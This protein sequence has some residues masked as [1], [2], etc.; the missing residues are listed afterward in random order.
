MPAVTLTPPTAAD[1]PD[2]IAAN[3]ASVTLHAPWVSPPTTQQALEAWL[4]CQQQPTNKSLIAR[5]EGAI[6]GVFNFSQIVHGN[7]CSAYLG[8]YAITGF[9][10]HGLM[11]HALAQAVQHAF[12]ELE[13]H[14]IETNIQPANHKSIALVQ[15]AGFVKEGFSPKYLRINGQWRDHE[16]WALVAPERT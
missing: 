10:G 9:T 11:T 14:R 1:G 15:R 16:R 7:F 13:L 6:C 12:T 5:H 2:L 8:F 3:Q 4:S